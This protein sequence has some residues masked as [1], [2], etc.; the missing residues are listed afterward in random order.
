MPHSSSVLGYNLILFTASC[1]WERLFRRNSTDIPSDPHHRHLRTQGWFSSRG[2]WMENRHFEEKS[3]YVSFSFFPC[4][5][6]E[7]SGHIDLAHRFQTEHFTPYLT[8]EKRLIPRKGDLTYY[9]WWAA[10]DIFS[11]FVFGLPRHFTHKLGFDF[12]EQRRGP[13]S[14]LLQ[15]WSDCQDA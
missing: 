7:I 14:F 15:L 4:C 11:L 13:L 9:N 3:F 10:T 2:H 5:R 8:G 6:I 12:Q 1:L